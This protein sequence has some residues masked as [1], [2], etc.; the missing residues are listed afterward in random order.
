M[1]RAALYIRV[2]TDDQTEYSPDAQKKQLIEYAKK[3]DYI[4]D[5][6]YIFSDEGISGRKAEIRPAFMHMISIAKTKPKPFDV[7]LVHRFDRFARNREDSVVYKSLLRKD[8]DI[9]VISITEQ[10]EDDKFSIILE[11]MLEAMAEYYS[12]NLADEVKKGMFEKANRGEHSGTL[13]LGYKLTN[14]ILQIDDYYSA[15][16]KEIF[17]LFVKKDYS[18]LEISRYLNNKNIR[19]KNNTMFTTRGLKYVIQNPCYYGAHRY[20][21]RQGSQS[22]ANDNKDWIIIENSHEPIISKEL[23]HK[24]QEKIYL[25]KLMSSSP[26]KQARKYWLS[27]LLRCKHCHG[28]MTSTIIKNKYVSYYCCNRKNGICKT[29]N[30]IS[31]NKLGKMVIETMEND[32]NNNTINAKRIDDKYNPEDQNVLN[33][34]LKTVQRKYVL[35]NDAYLAEIDTLEEYKKKKSLIR[36]EEEQTLEELNKI[37]NKIKS[38]FNRIKFKNNIELLK[39]SELTQLEKNKIIKTFVDKIVISSRDKYIK[40]Y[41]YFIG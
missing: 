17:E 28:S 24:A 21:Y 15:I 8:C 4:I 31:L 40:I 33:L 14:K 9:K 32:L 22:I 35:A 1:E 39:S 37:N 29:P 2:S 30:N 20:N 16:V 11:A 7:I 18:V 41:Y 3:N 10:L 23:W 12:L 34:K 13:P 25:S 19:T 27:G 5:Y 26:K 38:S 6:N 36:T